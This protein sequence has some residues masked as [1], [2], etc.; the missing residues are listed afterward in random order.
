MTV[1]KAQPISTA[2]HY[3][4]CAGQRTLNGFCGLLRSNTVN[5][6]SA[7]ATTMTGNLTS[8]A[9]GRSASVYVNC[10]VRRGGKGA[11]KCG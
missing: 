4:G 2:P 8:A 5:F 6:L 11:S 9:Y 1:S 3:K 10:N 7:V